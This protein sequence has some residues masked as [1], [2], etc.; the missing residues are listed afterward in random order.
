MVVGEYT[1]SNIHMD[2]DAREE[3]KK[4][5]IVDMTKLNAD[6]ATQK[7][8][9]A[10]GKLHEALEGLLNLEKM[11]RLAEDITAAKASCSAVL[12][13][14]YQ[15]KQWK[16]LEEQ[17]ML[18]AKRR[19]Q[20][21]QAIQAFVRQAMTYI[22]QT[23]DK[24]TKVSLI[25]TLE[26]VTEGKIF[27]EIERARLTRKLAA[28]KEAEGNV[29]EAADILQEVA[30]ETFGAM[31][32]TE[33]IAFILE[34]V[35][36]CLDKQD[37][38]RAQILSRKISPKAFVEKKGEGKGEIGIEGT[39]IE[40]ADVG[41]PSLPELKLSYY[42]L[43]IRYYGHYN[44]YLEMTRCYRAIYDMEAV[45]AEP[46]KWTAVLKKIC[47]FIALSPAY[48]TEG[49]SSSDHTTLL[50]LTQQDKKLGSLPEYKALLETF[51]NNEI[52][53]WPVLHAQYQ[54]EIAAQPD[55]FSEPKRLEDLK[56]RTIEHNVAVVAKYYTRI[57]TQRLSQLLDLSPADAEKHLADMVVS[58]AVAAKIDRPAGVVSFGKR[59]APEE[60]LNGWS[61]NIS[62]LLEL[63]EKSCQ[64]IQKECM[65]GGV[66][67]GATA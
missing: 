50:T 15:A 14:C 61:S 37:Y 65:R 42:T 66:T 8:L 35:R 22:D 48:S 54:A 67:L 41:I 25:K 58:K 28:I 43:M 18:L 53:R 34:Q 63:V 24:E 27:V 17:I 4:T 31:A 64:Q 51:A 20:L 60:L 32:K 44:N 9:A 16:L 46:D 39:A 21:K 12:E 47:W 29:A 62:K 52:I 40:E 23:P 26:T 38:I 56:L 5:G 1:A 6:I 33:K 11:S 45:Q 59:E 57:S 49:G 10:Q 13:V 55:I 7:E 36:L 30:V 19:S 3:K 2:E